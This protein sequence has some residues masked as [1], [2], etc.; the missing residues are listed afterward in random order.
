M[1]NGDE[2][3][4]KMIEGGTVGVEQTKS[5][6]KHRGRVG[7]TCAVFFSN[8]RRIVRSAR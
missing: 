4:Q 8:D 2:E 7:G 6:Q 3:C 5:N 1:E